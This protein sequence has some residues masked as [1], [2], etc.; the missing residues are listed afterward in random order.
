M[1]RI[2][3]SLIVLLSLSG[4]VQSEFVVLRNPITGEVK[5]CRA[6]S[7]ASLTPLIQTAI[8]NSA[9]RSCA[10]GYQAAGYT[11]MN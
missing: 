9:T 11:R 6:T 5:E 10:A 1:V 4:C 3:A 8:D 7:G 2:T